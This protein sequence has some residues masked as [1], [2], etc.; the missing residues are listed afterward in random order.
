MI[1]HIKAVHVIMW[2]LRWVLYEKVLSHWL[3]WCGS[4]PVCILICFTK[5]LLFEKTLSNWL[6]WYGF[7][8][9]CVLKCDL[10]WLLWK[11]KFHFAALIWF[12]L[13]ACHHM[14]FKIGSWGESLV[15]LAALMWFI[16]SVCRHMCYKITRIWE[17]LVT[18]AAMHV[19]IWN[20]RILSNMYQPG[21]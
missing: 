18:L 6:H 8:S 15:T 1:S 17:S 11:K 21:C 4:S 12:L 14:R 16:T 9:V 13:S 20:V 19:L 2:D 10:R 3:H 5:L 7:S